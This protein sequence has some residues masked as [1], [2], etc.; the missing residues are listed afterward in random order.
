MNL[1]SIKPGCPVVKQGRA[2]AFTAGPVTETAL[3]RNAMHLV[4]LLT[5][6]RRARTPEGLAEQAVSAR[7]WS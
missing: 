2:R 4:S 7:P 6:K 3:H 1:A 5:P